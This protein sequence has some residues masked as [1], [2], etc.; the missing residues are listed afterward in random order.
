MHDSPQPPRPWGLSR[1]GPFGPPEQVPAYQARLDP[2]TQTARYFTP[3][4]RPIRAGEHRKT[5]KGTERKT[6]PKIGPDGAEP[7]AP[8]HE[9]DEEQ[10]DD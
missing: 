10:Q 9:Q 1:M 3:E 7:G 5:R 8:D 4:G 2:V 6:A